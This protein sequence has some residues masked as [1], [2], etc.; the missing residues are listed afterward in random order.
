MKISLNNSEQFCFSVDDVEE[1]ER[2]A[3]DDEADE[4][5]T[6]AEEK[7]RLERLEREKWLEEEAA[8]AN[9]S[10]KDEEESDGQF[11]HRANRA[12]KRMNSK[13]DSLP[14]LPSETTKKTFK[15][16]SSKMPLQSLVSD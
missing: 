5:N 12:I 10:K 9:N 13:Q 14:L 1:L 16:P 7:R 4:E 3:S 15:S 2:R 6:E 8:K 11:F